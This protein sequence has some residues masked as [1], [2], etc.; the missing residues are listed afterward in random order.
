M[1]PGEKRVYCATPPLPPPTAT[2]L[3]PTQIDPLT[4]WPLTHPFCFKHCTKILTHLRPLQKNRLKAMHKVGPTCTPLLFAF[5]PTH[6]TDRSN[7]PNPTQPTMPLTL[8]HPKQREPKRNKEKQVTTISDFAT[9][10]SYCLRERSLVVFMFS[11]SL[12][13]L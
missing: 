10:H 13:H 6:Q 5:I 12:L 9:T 2:A 4:H 7:P 1:Q 11:L 8:C 3:A